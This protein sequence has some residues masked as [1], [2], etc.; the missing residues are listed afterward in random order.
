MKNGLRHPEPL[1]L[2]PHHNGALK[3]S[4]SALETWAT[5]MMGVS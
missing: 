5:H 3:L 2:A 4:L 1:G